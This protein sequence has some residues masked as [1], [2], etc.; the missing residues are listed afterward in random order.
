MRKDRYSIGDYYLSQHRTSPNWCATWFDKSSRQTRRASLGTVDFREAQLKLA[1]WVVKHGERRDE[2]PEDVLLDTVWVRYYEHHGSK[3]RSKEAIRYGLKKW[4]DYFAGLAVADLTLKRQEAFVEHLK[5]AGCS[6]GYINRIFS[7]GIAA[8]NW[9]YKH[10][11]ITHVPF[12]QKPP[13]GGQRQRILALEETAALFNAIQHDRLFM[14]C[15]I[16]FNTLARPEAILELQPFQVDFEA[17]LLDLNPQGRVQTKKHRPVVPL[18][19]TLASCLTGAPGAHYVEWR[20]R[21]VKSIQKLFRDTRKRAGLSDDVSPY[22]IRHTMASQLRKRGVPQWEVQ[23]FMGH[24]TGGTTEIY[25][26]YDPSYLSEAARAID[27]YFAELHGLL[28]PELQIRLR[29][30]SVLA[31]RERATQA[32]EKLVGVTGFEPT[33]PA[34][35]R[36]CSTRLSYT[37]TCSEI[38]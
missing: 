35:R 38:Y 20:G 31:I 25:A 3:V 4:S 27:A 30:S 10:Q 12:I 17:G 1:E 34:S 6:A 21:P 9:A 18:T 2:R 22:T 13:K 29:V 26:K 16:A 32:V 37:P 15:A 19:K 36:Q 28:S 24:K 7:S 14:Y 33:T 23:G 8:L 11:E 5:N